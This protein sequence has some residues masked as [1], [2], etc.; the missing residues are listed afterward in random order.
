MKVMFHIG[1][2]KAGS[3][4]LQNQVFSNCDKVNYIGKTVSNYPETLIDLAYLNDLDWNL[5]KIKIKNEIS[6][7]FDLKKL[8]LLSSEA[9]CNTAHTYRNLARI[10]EIFPNCQVLY[11]ERSLDEVKKSHYLYDVYHENVTSYYAGYFDNTNRPMAL[12]KCK[13]ENL[14]ESTLNYIQDACSYLNLNLTV[15]N[16]NQLIT[17]INESNEININGYKF[18]ANSTTPENRSLPLEQVA[19]KFLENIELRY[20]FNLTD[21]QRKKIQLQFLASLDVDE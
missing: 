4:F 6:I 12:G 13:S 3:T 7:D 11:V 18:I 9:V 21:Q 5:K 17:E 8:N 15:M 2:R 20:G 16:F 1:S 19:K 14:Y 10:S